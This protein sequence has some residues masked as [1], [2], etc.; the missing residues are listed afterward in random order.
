MGTTNNIAALKYADKSLR[1][2]SEFMHEMIKLDA[3]A[4][5]YTTEGLRLDKKFVTEAIHNNKQVIN[6]VSDDFKS[7]P[8]FMFNAIVHKVDIGEW[9]ENEQETFGGWK[10]DKGRH[11]R[12][13]SEGVDCIDVDMLDFL[14]NKLKSNKEFMLRLLSIDS[15][16]IDYV[17]KDLLSDLEVQRLGRKK[18]ECLDSAPLD[19][20][21]NKVIVLD[22]VSNSGWQLEFASDKLKADK[23]VV[24]LAVKSDGGSL[25]FADKILKNDQ[26]VVLLALANDE[27][28]D[29]PIT[30]ASYQLISNKEFMLRAVRID[31]YTFHHASTDLMSD[32]DLII[33]TIVSA[34][35]KQLDV[36]NL[37]WNMQIPSVLRSD[38]DY[39][40]NMI[41]I[42]SVAFRFCAEDLQNSRNFVSLAVRLNGSVLKYVSDKFK[43]DR[44]I[45]SAAAQSPYPAS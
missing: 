45:V 35:H 37:I 22:V 15:H 5:E 36:D 39:M 23:K 33:K 16:V 26:E 4:F 3:K 43:S 14:S 19:V 2:D 13:R 41:Q 7:D 11:I 31:P 6:H 8:E 42:V 28:G 1:S 20:R 30:H 38:R 21:N 40:M 18:W 17:H 25:K 29:E 32:K 34:K 44:Q 10:R 12:R 9:Y 27:N 24:S